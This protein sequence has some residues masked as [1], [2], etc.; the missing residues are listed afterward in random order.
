MV[1]PRRHS[2]IRM[3]PAIVLPA[4]LAF[5]CSSGPSG[6][7]DLGSAPGQPGVTPPGATDPAQTFREV[8][9]YYISGNEGALKLVPETHSVPYTP[10][11]ATAALDE[12]VHGTPHQADHSTPFPRTS[13]ILA[14]TISGGVATVDWSQEVLGAT[15]P[16]DEEAMGIQSV[17]WTL[18]EFPSIDSVRFT[19]EG[20]D[21]G[22]VPSGRLIENWWGH[23]GLGAQ[24]LDPGCCSAAPAGGCLTV[25]MKAATLIR[26]GGVLLNCYARM[27]GLRHCRHSMSRVQHCPYPA[28]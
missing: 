10:R 7:V 23:V 17:V 26:D 16:A 12:L 9:I 11:V 20:R 4:L 8:T 14:V 1:H 21:R 3:L 15:V 27:T 25:V 13:N 5:G 18:T 6:V 24:A 2:F 22:Q 28:A 19:V